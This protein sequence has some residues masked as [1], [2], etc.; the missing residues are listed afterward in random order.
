MRSIKEGT[1]HR[2]EELGNDKNETT[3]EYRKVISLGKERIGQSKLLSVF[4][5]EI[6][7]LLARTLLLVNIE[8][9]WTHIQ[10]EFRPSRNPS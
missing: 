8:W 3:E 6:T 2:V 10:Q 1:N 9:T 5:S 4:I 7:R